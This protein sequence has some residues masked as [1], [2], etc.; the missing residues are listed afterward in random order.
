MLRQGLGLGV[1]LVAAGLAG[2]AIAQEVTSDSIVRQPRQAREVKLGV[3]GR[4]EHDTNIARSSKTLAAQQNIVPEDTIYTPTAN[5]RVIV[6]VGRQAVFVNG[7]A[8]YLFHDKNTRLDDSRINGAAGIANR[9]GPCASVLAGTYQRGRNELEDRILLTNVSN[10]LEVRGIRG[11]VTCVRAPGL[12]IGFSGSREWADNSSNLI[13]TGAYET[14]SGGAQLMY[15][16]PALGEF[17]LIGT[18]STTSYKTRPS[19]PA[20]GADKFDAYGAGVQV[21]RQLGGRIEATGKFSYTWVN[22]NQ[23]PTAP[24]ALRVSDYQG[25]TYE[26]QLSIKPS[27]RLQSRFTFNREVVPSFIQG[28]GFEISEA[29][30]GLLSYSLGS[31]IVLEANAQRQKR[32]AKGVTIVSPVPRLTDSTVDIGGLAIRYRQSQR[33]SFTLSGQIEDR[34]AND[35]LF[36]YRSNRIGLSADVNF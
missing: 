7:F 24:A 6:P 36:E 17:A 16:R 28:Q 27:S 34:N 22:V 8:S 9:L 19:F 32:H 25:P 20:S 1:A 2:S 31:R 11:D 18:Y 4:V 12:G 29:Y 30:G 10:I 14:T 23:L 26:A 21:K 5:L 15:Q 33:L 13:A 3:Q 35:P